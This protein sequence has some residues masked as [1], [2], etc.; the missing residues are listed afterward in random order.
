MDKGNVNPSH[1]IHTLAKR[2]RLKNK[3]DFST[4]HI[5]L[6]I[7]KHLMLIARKFCGT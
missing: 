6:A 7:N 4:K 5:Q 2:L 3:G 1:S